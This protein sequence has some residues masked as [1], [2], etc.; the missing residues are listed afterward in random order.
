MPTLFK[1]QLDGVELMKRKD[2]FIQAD[3]M[4]MGKTAQAIEYMKQTTDNHFIVVCPSSLKTNWCREIN[5]WLGIVVKPDVYTGNIIV[6]N[7]E[8]VGRMIDLIGDYVYNFKGVIFDEAHA[9]KNVYAGRTYEAKRLVDKIGNPMMLTGTPILNRPND[10]LGLL[11]VG[12]KLSE[13]GGIEAYTKRYIPYVERDNAIFFSDF[14]NLDEL[15]EKIKPFICRR[16]RCDIRRPNMPVKKTEVSLGNFSNRPLSSVSITNIQKVESEIMKRKL[17]LVVDWIKKDYDTHRE[18]LVVFANHRTMIDVLHVMFP[19]S[20]VLYG[21]MTYKEK[22]KSVQSFLCGESDIILCSLACAACGLNLIRSHRVVFA[23]FPWTK[24]IFE[25]AIARCARHGQTHTTEVFAL[26]MENSYDRYRLEQMQWKSVIADS[27]IDGDKKDGR[28][29]VGN[30][31]C[32]ILSY[33]E[34]GSINTSQYFGI[35]I[36]STEFVFAVAK[37]SEDW[38]RVHPTRTEEGYV[39]WDKLFRAYIQTAVLHQGDYSLERLASMVDTPFHRLKLQATIFLLSHSNYKETEWNWS[40]LG[41]LWYP[42]Y[43]H[44]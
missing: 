23:E 1:Y 43:Q 24:G 26:I 41:R 35:D 28:Y 6:T 12:G 32:N 40:N 27:I 15:H 31:P 39:Y 4:G 19:N 21:G 36:Y 17:P 8:K 13:F 34:D 14:A 3:D 37:M 44:K 7:Y 30:L 16:Q 11:Y 22:E 5:E 38:I 18:P 10:L 29:R 9:I 33:L 20:V 42:F 25:Q 2:T